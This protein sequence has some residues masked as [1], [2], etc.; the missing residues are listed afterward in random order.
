MDLINQKSPSSNPKSNQ[1]SKHDMHLSYVKNPNKNR[2]NDNVKIVMKK[3]QIQTL[4]DARDIC[5]NIA[6]A[7]TKRNSR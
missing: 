2:T 6:Q 1:W 5:D 3:E 4:Q 7:I